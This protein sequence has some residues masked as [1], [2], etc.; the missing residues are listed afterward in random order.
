MKIKI[1]LKKGWFP[2]LLAFYVIIWA[3]LPVVQYGTINR[4]LVAM[5]ALVW[6]AVAVG[7]SIAQ[8][9]SKI[10]SIFSAVIIFT[11]LTIIVGVICD[12]GVYATFISR[13]HSIIFLLILCMGIYYFEKDPEFLISI[14]KI[15]IP[16]I[17][18][19]A[20][21]T[22]REAQLTPGISRL[23]VWDVEVAREYARKGVGGYGLIY[24]LVFYASCLLYLISVKVIKR[25]WLFALVVLMFGLT[26]FTSGFLI[27][28]IMMVTSIF[29]FVFGLY[30]K[31][32]PLRVIGSILLIVG[33]AYLVLQIVVIN[34]GDKLVAAFDGTLYETKIREIVLLFQEE[35]NVGHLEGRTSRYLESIIAM[36]RFPLLGAKIA[37]QMEAIGGHST[38]FDVLATYGLVFSF[39]YYYAM[40]KAFISM[41]RNKADVGLVSAFTILLLINGCF[42]TFS[43]E[44]AV[45]FFIV[46][47]AT[48]LIRM[49]DNENENYMDNAFSN[50]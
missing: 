35:Q 48:I 3:V 20:F 41:T 49:K 28:S 1:S 18:V 36:V 43:Y 25:K 12:G 40:Y 26:V 47:P 10:I 9:N 21:L 4:L 27:A 44:H 11:A 46:F 30:S 24:S 17:L 45:A 19:V 38:L 42:N 39:G 16:V 2:K 50:A 8:H 32:D 31:K 23:M 37:N 14:T 22:F 15:V 34:N 13:L 5:A 33:A 7:N 29:V 6:F